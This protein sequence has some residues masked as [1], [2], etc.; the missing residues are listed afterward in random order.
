MSD[1]ARAWAKKVTGLR[2]AEKSVLN[3]LA[4][5]ADADGKAWPKVNT[6]AT[7]T[8]MSARHVVRMLNRLEEGGL[9]R[10]E[11]RWRN[12]GGNTSNVYWLAIPEDELVGARSDTRVSDKDVR[13]L[14]G[15][16]R[17]SCHP[18]RTSSDLSL[19]EESSARAHSSDKVGTNTVAAGRTACAEDD[20]SAAYGSARTWVGVPVEIRDQI[21]ALP[22]LGEGWAGSWLDPCGW[23]ADT[24]ALIPR[25][26]FAR[27]RIEQDLRPHLKALNISVGEPR[28]RRQ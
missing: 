24:R 5:Y 2:I 1:E 18:Y 11:P 26:H 12:S 15:R 19:S 14:S 25:T 4:G 8:G 27:G 13:P 16:R 10:R 3:A 21:V 23:E 7:I 6:L 28:G 22:Q 20:P 17:Q 9:L